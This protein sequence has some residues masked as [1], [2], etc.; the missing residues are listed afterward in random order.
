MRG[1]IG[2]M[3]GLGIFTRVAVKL[4]PYYG[5]P[6]IESY[7]EPPSY[8]VKVPDTFRVYTIGFPSRDNVYEAMRL[9]QEEGIVFWCS[10]RGPFTQAAAAT[11]SNMELASIW[12]TEEFKKKLADYAYNVTIGLNASSPREM[13]YKDKAVHQ[14]MEK[15]DGWVIPETE[16]ELT[17]R[18]LHGFMSL[19][20]VK[21][22]FRSTG[23]MGSA[24]FAEET[25]DSLNLLQGKVI[26]LKNKY[27]KKGLLLPDGDSTWVTLLEDFA[28]HMETPVRY[29]PVNEASRQA[30]I[31]YSLKAQDV[32]L[33]YNID[34]PGAGVGLPMGKKT[35]PPKTLDFV[36]WINKIKKALDPNDVGDESMGLVPRRPKKRPLEN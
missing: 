13:D 3:G 34:L 17:A 4:V 15:L 25:G 27:G 10:R 26:E 8:K 20:A 5:P 33:E 14:L 19:G 31:E 7:G 1:I 24:P 36:T 23:G 22:T 6:K 2:H 18:F 28:F 12:E 32:L 16:D 29:D 35:V 11:A 30:V 21:G 9:L